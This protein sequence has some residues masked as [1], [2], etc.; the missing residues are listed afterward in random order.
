M[1]AAYEAIEDALASL[2]NMQTILNDTSVNEQRKLSLRI[3]IEYSRNTLENQQS[4]LDNRVA[5]VL[6]NMH[7]NIRR[8]TSDINEY[9]S[10]NNIKLPQR[11]AEISD[12]IGD[13][14]SLSNIGECLTV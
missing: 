5:D 10:E 12:N 7:K 13:A 11:I 9:L 4:E 3:Q 6:Q 8:T 14:I 1:D 2:T